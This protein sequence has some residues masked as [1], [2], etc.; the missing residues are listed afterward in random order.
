MSRNSDTPSSSSNLRTIAQTFRLTG[1]I[2]FWIQLVL[3]VVSGI[4]VLLFAIFSQRAGSPSNNPGTGF[5]VF[6]AVC[7]LLILCGG[8][9]IAFRY[10]RIGNQLMSSNPSNR[11]RK[12]ETVQVLR[13]GLWIN[14]IGTL[15]TLL[16]A[17]AIVG[18]LVA[19]SI[20]PQ[21]I[22]T[23]FFDPTRIISGL[24]M[25]VVQSNTNTVSAHFAGLVAS[26]W[27]LNRINRQQ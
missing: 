12:V 8:I 14:L 6:L 15:V 19:R 7:G 5:G 1:W 16:G 11:P 24:D 10:T 22:T 23:Q 27:L 18:T 4:I 21:A 20:S 3:G 13:L 2:S 17:Q 26:L 9:Y 25:L